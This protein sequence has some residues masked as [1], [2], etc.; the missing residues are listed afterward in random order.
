M[1][2]SSLLLTASGCKKRPEATD[3]IV[4][5]QRL[6]K[7]KIDQTFQ[8]ASPE[9]LQSVETIEM[10]SRYRHYDTVLAELDKLANNSSLTDAQKKMVGQLT[11]SAKQQQAASKPAH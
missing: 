9:V 11:D 7:A 8:G 6:D 1:L 5:N 2:A 4:A 10:Q 3:S